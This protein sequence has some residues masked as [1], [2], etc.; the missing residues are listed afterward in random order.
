MADSLGRPGYDWL[1][2]EMRLEEGEMRPLHLV[3]SI[4]SRD[5]KDATYKLAL[6]RALAEIAQ[7]QHHPADRKVENPTNLLEHAVRHAGGGEYSVFQ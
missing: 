5:K 2:L 3:E 7:K 4:L 6:F 1:V